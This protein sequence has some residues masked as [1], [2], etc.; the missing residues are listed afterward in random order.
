[1]TGLSIKQTVVQYFEGWKPLSLTYYSV[2]QMSYWWAEDPPRLAERVVQVVQQAM[3]PDNP[4]TPLQAKRTRSASFDQRLLSSSINAFQLPQTPVPSAPPPDNVPKPIKPLSHKLAD[5]GVRFVIVYFLF[6]LVGHASLYCNGSLCGIKILCAVAV[7][8]T[9]KE[10]SKRLMKSAFLHGSMAITDFAVGHLSLV[11]GALYALTP[12]G[13]L[14][15]QE[16]VFSR[17]ET[18][19]SHEGKEASPPPDVRCVYERIADICINMMTGSWQ[20]D[21]W[22]WRL[23]AKLPPFKKT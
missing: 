10:Q 23:W 18:T 21:K 8:N 9:D 12:T 20:E 19:V 6:P 14:S 7:F 3:H 2:S 1:M 17:Y 5:G 16:V 4:S 22:Y 11:Y 13:V 15:V